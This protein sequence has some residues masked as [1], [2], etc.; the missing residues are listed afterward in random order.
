MLF[1]LAIFGILRDEVY[2]PINNTSVSRKY[3]MQKKNVCWDE[4]MTGNYE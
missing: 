2:R 1:Q 3:L 4:A